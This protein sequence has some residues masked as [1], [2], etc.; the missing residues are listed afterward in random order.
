[1]RILIVILGT[2]T[3]ALAAGIFLKNHPGTFILNFGDT[4]IQASLAFFVASILFI[5]ITLSITFVVLNGLINLP[6]NYRRWKKHRRNRRSE[7]YLAKGLMSSF[8][9]DWEA[10]E[11]AFRKG[12]AYSRLPMLNYLGAARS[13]QRQGNVKQRDHYLR[14]AH[15]YSSD[16]EIIVGL[17]QAELQLSQKQTEQA[18]ATL[19]HLKGKGAG[20][21]RANLMLLRACSELKEWHG[22][23]EILEK[24]ARKGLLRQEEIKAKQ[25]IAYTGLLQ[26]AGKAAD[27]RRLEEVWNNI[28]RKLQKEF[29]ILEVYINERLRFPDTADCE[30]LLREVLKH[31][32]DPALVRLFGLVK[33]TDGGRQLAFAERLLKTHARDPVLLLSIGRLCR[34]NSLWGKARACFEESLEIQP[35]PEAY[36]E[37]ATLLEQQGDHAGAAECYQKG[38]NLVTG[39]NDAS[40]EKLLKKQA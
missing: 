24:L 35:G 23:L 11:Q 19:K 28:P 16:P 36:Q 38:L 2:L 32:W 15:E 7:K 13:A 40:T 21:D 9:G 17:T 18:Y 20:Q 22:V 34:R 26:I 10:A 6:R 12:A 39:I 30:V 27:R 3:A 37:L 25:L 31:Q 14:L 29:Y 1:M 33:G 5:S 8:E 4:T